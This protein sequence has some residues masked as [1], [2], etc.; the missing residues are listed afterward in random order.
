[1]TNSDL[2]G[3]LIHVVAAVIWH[4]HQVDTFLISQRQQGKHLEYFWE[5]PGGKKK[6]DETRERALQREL[7]EEI[8]IRVTD[9]S[10]FMQVKHEYSDRSILL[11]V[12][13]VLSFDGN[14]IGNEGQDIRWIAI[15]ELNNYRF[16]EADIPVLEAI[17]NSAKA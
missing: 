17:K 11:D 9:T 12:W 15:S 5:L 4:P 2:R 8:C 14:A 13:Q 16:P 6:S 3:P 10:P 1:M 7:S